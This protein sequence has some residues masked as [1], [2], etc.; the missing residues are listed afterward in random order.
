MYGVKLGH[1]RSAQA[2]PFWIVEPILRGDSKT[3]R[4]TEN[5]AIPNGRILE[6]RGPREFLVFDNILYGVYLKT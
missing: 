5:R 1:Y 3:G 6:V 4:V 2:L